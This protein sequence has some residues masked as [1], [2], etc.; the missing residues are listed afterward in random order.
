MLACTLLQHAVTAHAAGRQY[1]G[2]P[3]RCWALWYARRVWSL[4]LQGQPCLARTDS[5][6]PARMPNH[7]HGSISH[8]APPNPMPLEVARPINNV[9]EPHCRRPGVKLSE[10]VRMRVCAVVC[11][12]LCP[13]LGKEPLMGMLP[14]FGLCCIFWTHKCC[15]S[16][17]AAPWRR[18]QDI[19]VCVRACMLVCVCVCVV[20]VSTLRAY[21]HTM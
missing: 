15:L 20:T 19:C 14:P 5:M 6:P 8:F 3:R 16:G 7:S 18:Q 11:W 9:C 4:G 12:V 17:A 13:L 10:C 1:L 2:V 21:I